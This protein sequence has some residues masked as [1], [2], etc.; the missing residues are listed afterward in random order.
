M[1]L[2]FWVSPKRLLVLLKENGG[3]DTI[4][5][6]KINGEDWGVSFIMK[7]TLTVMGFDIEIIVRLYWEGC[8]IINETTKVRYPEDGSSNFKIFRDNLEISLL[9]AGLFFEKIGQLFFKK[10]IKRGK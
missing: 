10:L 4:I 5:A 2:Q 1:T 6:N 3:V 8:A 9:H 7:G